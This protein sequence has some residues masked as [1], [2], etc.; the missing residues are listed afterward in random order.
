MNMDG[1]FIEALCERLDTDK[2]K[3]LVEVEGKQFSLQHLHQ[4]KP[5]APVRP[6]TLKVTTLESLSKYI[7]DNV[8]EVQTD[9]C[10]LH[11]EDPN[12]VALLSAF[13]DDDWKQRTRYIEAEGP[14]CSFKFGV[15]YTQE[16][17][18]MALNRHFA[19]TEDRPKLLTMVSNIVTEEAITS[20]DDGLHQ[21]V[22]VKTGTVK[23][24]QQEVPRYVTLRPHR[25]FLEVEQVQS[26]FLLRMKQGTDKRPIITL[27]EI[28]GGAWKL[29]ATRKVCEYLDEKL[30]DI[31]ILA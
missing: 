18:I 12:K 4:V 11:I 31:T 7:E 20:T 5:E 8:D 16:A 10:L 15:D 25:Y 29:E 23:V 6:A 28:D 21:T 27:H 1:S 30:E 24:A 9:K 17:F 22:V 14:G 13:S 2:I 3:K 19:E 26:Q